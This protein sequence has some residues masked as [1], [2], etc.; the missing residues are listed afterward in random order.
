MCCLSEH[1]AINSVV[2]IVISIIPLP[3][4]ESTPVFQIIDKICVTLFIVDYILRLS[5]ADYKYE[6]QSILSFARYPF[7]LMAIIDLL[8][9]LPSFLMISKGFKLLRL[10]R[11]ARTLRT[12]Y[13]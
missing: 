9:I 7:S 3:F 13:L 2:V 10:L 5:T 4:K 11:M 12:P 6:S 8:S 1:Y